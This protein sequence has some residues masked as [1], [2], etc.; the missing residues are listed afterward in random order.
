MFT[1]EWESSFWMCLRTKDCYYRAPH[2][3]TPEGI[4]Y[5]MEKAPKSSATRREQCKPDPSLHSIFRGVIS[6]LPYRLGL[7][8]FLFSVADERFLMVPRNLAAHPP[9]SSVSEQSWFNRLAWLGLP[10]ISFDKTKRWVLSPLVPIPYLLLPCPISHRT[11][12]GQAE[13][14]GS[15]ASCWTGK[16]PLP[17]EMR[18][19]AGHAGR[20]GGLPER[21]CASTAQTNRRKLRTSDQTAPIFSI[22]SSTLKYQ[23]LFF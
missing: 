12:G 22:N 18:G 13:G 7:E 21:H 6:S 16:T 8:K 11:G 3:N 10:S 14:L 2:R 9:C 20:A 4:A 17:E 19:A 1:E 23:T 5:Y 15:R